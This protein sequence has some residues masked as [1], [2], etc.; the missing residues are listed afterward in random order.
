MI[1]NTQSEQRSLSL[2]CRECGRSNS[3]E[4]EF[5]WKT[6]SLEL[7][8]PHCNHSPNAC[9]W[10]KDRKR[11]WMFAVRWNVADRDRVR[12]DAKRLIQQHRQAIRPISKKLR[13]EMLRRDESTCRYCGRSAP[14][15]ELHVD[16]VVPRAKGGL[17]ISENLVTACADCNLGK[18]AG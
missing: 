8:C 3:F 4:Y 18:G 1:R 11:A 6:G 17:T 10:D 7:S 9:Y 12:A 15:V 13:F 2:K 14:D 5:L 16:H